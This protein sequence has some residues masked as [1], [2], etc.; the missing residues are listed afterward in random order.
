M[1]RRY[2]GALRICD[3]QLAVP[4]RPAHRARVSD[5]VFR[6]KAAKDRGLGLAV[7]LLE[8][9]SGVEE[10]VDGR[11]VERRSRAEGEAQA[12]PAVSA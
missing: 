4:D 1:A 12:P 11:D 2:R 3:P 9:Y 5:H 6:V 8:A 7:P 10:A